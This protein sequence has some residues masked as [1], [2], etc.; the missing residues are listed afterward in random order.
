M[1]FLSVRKV[2]Q[3]YAEQVVLE[4]LSIEVAAGEFCTLVGASGCGKST[5]L[6]LLLGQERPAKGAILL[7]G[8]PIAAEPDVTR[9]I[10]FQR[11]SVFPHLSVLDNVLL[12]LELPAA[13]LSGRLYGSARRRARAEAEAMLARVGL[14]SALDKFPALLSGGMQQRLAIAQAL[15]MKPRM[16]LLDEPFGALDPGIRRDMHALLLELWRETGVTVFMVTHDISE[17]FALGTRLLVFDKRRHD[18]QHPNAYGAHITYDLPLN[19]NRR[20]AMREALQHL[21]ARLTHDLTAH[22]P[23]SPSP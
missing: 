4:D 3:C 8:K 15:V 18:P 23:F 7:D 12:G 21:R 20:A 22:D 17:G 10:V 5:F 9:G 1:S 16:L 13:R 11:Y 6:R 14:D 2:W 19:Q